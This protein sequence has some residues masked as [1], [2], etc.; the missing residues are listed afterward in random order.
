M[1]FSLFLGGLRGK[2]KIAAN[3]RAVDESE[4]F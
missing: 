4:F 3:L 2:K 1:L